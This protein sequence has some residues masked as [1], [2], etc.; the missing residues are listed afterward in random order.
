VNATAGIVAT[1]NGAMINALFSATSGGR[2]SNSED[3]FAVAEPYMRSVWDAPPGQELPSTAALLTD[4]RTPTWT[5]AYGGFHSL[6]RWNHTWTMAQMSCVI[7]DFADRAV[8]NVT[9][10]NI[11]SRSTSGRV[12]E[13]QFVTDQGTFTETG[14]E[15]RLAMQ[16]INSSGIP[17][18][19]PSTLFVIDR[20]TNSSGALTGY[21]VYGGGNGHGAGMPQT[22]A[23]GM[24]RAGHTYQQILQKYYTGIVL[25]VKNG[26]RRDGI[27]PNPV[28]PVD[29]YDCTSA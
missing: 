18:M 26:T 9:A 20:L 12:T 19:L 5:G 7:G 16:Y 13:V 4:L 22:G 14:T 6:H 25:Q 11:L 2:T 3:V 27:S 15:I 17:T 8:G 24:A 21:R 28:T 10:I 23:V 29:P 1:Y